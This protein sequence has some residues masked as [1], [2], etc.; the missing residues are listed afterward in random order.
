MSVQ[1]T[2]KW[3]KRTSGVNVIAL[4]TVKEYIS[5]TMSCHNVLDYRSFQ[6]QGLEVTVYDA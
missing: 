3:L 4:S 6:W 1:P 5:E 2:G